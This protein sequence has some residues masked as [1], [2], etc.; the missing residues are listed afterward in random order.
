MQLNVKTFGAVGDGVRDDTAAVQAAINAQQSMTGGEVLLPAGTYL[1]SSLK[2]GPTNPA[3]NSSTPLV[4]AGA[5][6]ETTTIRTSTGNIW[7]VPGGGARVAEL[8]ISDITFDGNYLGVPPHAG[9]PLGTLEASSLAAMV[10]LP[11]PGQS[12]SDASQ[13]YSGRLHQFRRVRFYRTV[14]FVFQP[15]KAYITGSVFDS[16]GQPDLPLTL[17]E[18]DTAL[19]S[20]IAAGEA[21]SSLTVSNLTFRVWP[22]LRVVLNPGK[23]Q[24][25]VILASASPAVA[26]PVTLTV[27][28]APIADAAYRSGTTVRFARAHNDTLG[29]GATTAIVVGN[30]FLNGCG[31]YADF[32][33]SP[34]NAVRLVF[35]NNTSANYTQGG[36]YALGWGSQIVNN[37]LHN[38]VPGAGINYDATSNKASYRG[39]NVVEGNTFGNIALPRVVAPTDRFA[40]N[41]IENR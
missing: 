32:V 12:I 18:G 38:M 21:I 3:R 22:G 11:Y 35:Q 30:Q 14:G 33:G 27:K 40:N 1:V 19:R 31:N 17:K 24:Q 6:M 20:D 4:V 7:S 9:F 13:L 8:V 16:D 2:D 28:G 23:T 10:N 15:T 29:S 5:G 25:V 39:N 36:I 41:T 34:L 26:G 37:N